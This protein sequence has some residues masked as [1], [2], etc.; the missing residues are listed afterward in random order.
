MMS[1]FALR[2]VL[3]IRTVV[4]AAAVL[5]GTLGSLSAPAS[6]MAA[7]PGAARAGQSVSL[8]VDDVRESFVNSGF[9][10]DEPHA[11]AWMAPPVTSLQ[12]HDPRSARVLRVLVYPSSAAAETARQQAAAR[13]SVEKNGWCAATGEACG[14]PHLVEGYGPSI[15]SGNVAMVQSTEPQLDGLFQAQMDI[16]NGVAAATDSAG[17]P[18]VIGDAVDFEFQ[19]ALNNTVANV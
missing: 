11:W 13:E 18:G 10:V 5:A 8:R 9:Q 6:T 7:E 1:R 12:I 17:Q 4:T 16:A 2:S 19:Q 15:W 14:T 3:S